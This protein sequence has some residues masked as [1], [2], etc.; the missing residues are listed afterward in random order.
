METDGTD[1]KL[2]A[3]LVCPP[4]PTIETDG[5]PDRTDQT[6]SVPHPFHPLLKLSLSARK[7]RH[8]RLRLPALLLYQEPD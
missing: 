3:R 8:P 5:A 1:Q 2:K 6:R 7:I 4:G